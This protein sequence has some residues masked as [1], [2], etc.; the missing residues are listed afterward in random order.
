[1]LYADEAIVV[2]EML[3]DRMYAEAKLRI[4][5]EAADVLFK[6]FERNVDLSMVDIVE[7]DD[8]FEITIGGCKLR[9]DYNKALKLIYALL[10]QSIAG[11]EESLVVASWYGI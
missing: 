11:L 10:T 6:M 5:R 2:S 7:T 9:L 4:L 3:L 8:G 1:M